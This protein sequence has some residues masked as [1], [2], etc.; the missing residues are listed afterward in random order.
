MLNKLLA[1]V[2]VILFF[3]TIWGME[4]EGLMNKLIYP[5]QQ[6]LEYSYCEFEKPS[7]RE[8]IYGTWSITEIEQIISNISEKC[9]SLI[10]E[11]DSLEHVEAL[12]LSVMFARYVLNVEGWRAF[13]STKYSSSLTDYDACIKI[14]ELSKT[15][16]TKLWCFLRTNYPEHPV[17]ESLQS[18][19][20]DFLYT[21]LE[22][23][24]SAEMLP[25]DSR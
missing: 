1:L 14:Q 23:E 25:E 9:K 4:Y 8:R 17:I 15:Y 12:F 10:N 11:S 13:A 7:E 2:S 6:V 24:K 20:G 3:N 21:V 5:S 19:M 18:K 16:A 22:I